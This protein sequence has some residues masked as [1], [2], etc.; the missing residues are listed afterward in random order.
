[1]ARGRVDEAVLA[2]LVLDLGPGQ[3]EEICRLFLEN[4]SR[5]VHA[6][7]RALDA[8]DSKAAA[9][10]AH[11]LKSA[12]GFIGATGLATL[13]AEVEAGPPAQGFGAILAGELEQTAAEL[14]LSVGRLAH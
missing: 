3:A 7:G 2:Q 10:S 4:A 8:G 5:E 9:R 6:V 13:C 11:R 14:S 12:S 1:M